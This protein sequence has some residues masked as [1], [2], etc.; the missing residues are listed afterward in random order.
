VI[1]EDR[2]PYSHRCGRYLV[3]DALKLGHRHRL[4]YCRRY[5]QPP[6]LCQFHRQY[7]WPS[8]VA[9]QPFEPPIAS[10]WAGTSIRVLYPELNTILLLFTSNN[11]TRVLF[12]RA[13]PCRASPFISK[14]KCDI[15]TSDSTTPLSMEPLLFAAAMTFP[16][17]MDAHKNCW[18]A[19]PD[20]DPVISHGPVG[21][22]SNAVV[23]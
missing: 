15:H 7:A 5:P 18:P 10:E 1:E 17:D 22:A 14:L 20:L 8:G 16:H 12:A 9:E 4:L 6:S 11:H 13:L 2:V 19:C 3:V 21:K 23:I